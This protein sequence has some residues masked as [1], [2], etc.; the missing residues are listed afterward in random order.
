MH[1]HE[2][3]HD[4]IGKKIILFKFIV[5]EWSIIQDND[6]QFDTH[7]RS[8]NE[9]IYYC[10]SEMKLSVSIFSTM[11]SDIPVRMFIVNSFHLILK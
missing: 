4:T 9:S 11:D 8:L 5:F 2:C 6:F 1:D 7:E 3:D 10:I